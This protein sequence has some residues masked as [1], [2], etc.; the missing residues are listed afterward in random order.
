MRELNDIEP[1]VDGKFCKKI[2]K[3][4]K[5]E[6]VMQKRRCGKCKRSQEEVI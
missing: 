4:C 5:E 1:D 2:C 6:M 3:F